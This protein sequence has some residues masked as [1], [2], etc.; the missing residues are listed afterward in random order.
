MHL[1]TEN[2]GKIHNNRNLKYIYIIAFAKGKTTG[3]ISCL[4]SVP[5]STQ[6]FSDCSEKH[7]QRFEFR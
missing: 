7:Q 3:V 1:A 2:V 5:N 4:L 6:L